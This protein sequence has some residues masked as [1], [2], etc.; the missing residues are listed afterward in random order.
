MRLRALMILCL[1]LAACSHKQPP[2][3][4]WTKAHWGMLPS[5]VM[6]AVPELT[7][8]NGS[9]LANGAA[10]QLRAEK[11][12]VADTALPA[13]FFFLDSR[14]VQ[15]MFGDSQYH[16]NAANEK[17]LDHLAAILRKQYGQESVGPALDRA[18]GLSREYTWTSGDTDIVLSAAPV[19]AT[20]SSYTII[21][22][23]AAGK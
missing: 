15:I 21:Y 20:T 4:Q 19:T 12:A 10:A 1:F 8:D 17:T 5:E 11:A 16:D 23:R 14:L 9:Q 3:I 18:A 7:P 22:R 13:R 2:A 6:T